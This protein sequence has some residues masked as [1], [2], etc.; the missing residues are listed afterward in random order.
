MELF[1]HGRNVLRALGALFAGMAG[2]NGI[3][4]AKGSGKVPRRILSL[5]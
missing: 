3:G 5:S 2:V 1:G 4:S